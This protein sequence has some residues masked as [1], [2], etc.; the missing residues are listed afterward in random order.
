MP[1]HILGIDVGG[2]NIK[3]GLIDHVGRIIRR[4][5]LSTKSYIRNKKILIDALL[6]HIHD[7]LYLENLK[8]KD[9]LGI[10]IG[11][12][13]LVD[14]KRGIVKSLTNIPGWQN[15][16]LKKIFQKSLKI[17]TFIENDVNLITLGEWKLGAGKGCQDLVCITLGTGVGGG[18]ILSNELY[19][20]AG[21]ATGE[22]GHIPLNEKGPVCNCGG[23]GCLEVHV[24]NR[25]LLKKAQEIFKKKA[26][27]IEDVYQLANRGNKLAIQFFEETATHIGNG[28]TGVVN[29]LNPRLIIIGG[30]ISN[31]WK[32][33]FRTIQQIIQGRAMKVQGKMVKIVRAKLGDDA[34]IMGAYVLVKTRMGMS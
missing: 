10:G 27:T 24:S 12:P 5:N 8:N 29:L 1:K 6:N 14:P 18:L 32:F 33:L 34:G 2:T 4:N 25:T 31:N 23:M 13:G 9:L 30:G 3:L 17:P 26:I 21:F 11:L 16:A 19:Y 22:V 15:V 20:G 7:L 28:L